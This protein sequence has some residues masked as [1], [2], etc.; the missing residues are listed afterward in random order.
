MI[1]LHSNI[2]ALPNVTQAG[3]ENSRL[4]TGE[5]VLQGMVLTD[6]PSCDGSGRRPPPR[7]QN[8]PGPWIPVAEIRWHIVK[9]CGCISPVPLCPARQRSQAHQDKACGRTAV[10]LHAICQGQGRSVLDSHRRIDDAMKT[11]NL[12]RRTVTIS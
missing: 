6:T 9:L 5:N 4:D 3:S 10:H 7:Q 8:S 12:A 1:V 2:S 11:S